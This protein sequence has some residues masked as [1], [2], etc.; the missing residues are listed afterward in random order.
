MDSGHASGQSTNQLSGP[1]IKGRA[2]ALEIH[3][4]DG[5]G[6]DLSIPDVQWTEWIRGDWRILWPSGV[7]PRQQ[8]W[9]IH[10]SATMDNAE[11]ASTTTTPMR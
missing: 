5:R 11:R 7:V 4:P 3:R 1:R 9:K 8:G 10:V 6:F 2:G